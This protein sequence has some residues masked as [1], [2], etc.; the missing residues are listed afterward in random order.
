MN[1]FIACTKKDAYGYGYKNYAIVEAE[2]YDEAWQKI[3]DGALLGDAQYLRGSITIF[4]VTGSRDD[5]FPNWLKLYTEQEEA[6]RSAEDR[7]KAHKEYLRLK[8]AYG[9]E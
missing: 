9:F 5:Q 8:S 7:D 6:A 1:K 3:L 4:E 2:N